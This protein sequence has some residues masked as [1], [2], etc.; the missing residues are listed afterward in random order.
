MSEDVL[1][2]WNKEGQMCEG[3]VGL[4]ERVM[5]LQVGVCER[6]RRGGVRGERKGERV[7]IKIEVK[8]IE[9]KKKVELMGERCDYI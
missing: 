9:D 6:E 1:R 3:N 4:S 7:E 8:V 2:F 5:C